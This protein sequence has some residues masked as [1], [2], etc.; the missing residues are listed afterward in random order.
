MNQKLVQQLIR[1]IESVTNSFNYS[2]S[3]EWVFVIEINKMI[4]YQ[5]YENSF[6]E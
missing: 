5:K 3:V 1:E 4:N 6:N 2:L